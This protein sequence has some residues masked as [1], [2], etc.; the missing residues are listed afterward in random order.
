MSALRGV[1]WHTNHKIVQHRTCKILLMWID[2]TSAKPNKLWSVRHAFKPNARAYMMHSLAMTD[3]LWCPCT[4]VMPSRIKM[5][6]NKGKN[7]HNVGSV[8]W[9][10]TTANGR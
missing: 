10:W 4:M 1:Q 9:S 7:A 6:R 2:A 8:T 5:L 3:V